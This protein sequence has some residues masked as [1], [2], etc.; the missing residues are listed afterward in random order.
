LRREK[1]AAEHGR[2]EPPLQFSEGNK[3]AS[4]SMW[5]LATMADHG[6]GDLEILA[7]AVRDSS[8][9]V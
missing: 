4:S 2:A 8:R 9:G 1:Q 5:Q 3:Q 6:D 7:S